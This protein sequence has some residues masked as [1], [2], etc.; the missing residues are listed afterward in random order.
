L[1]SGTNGLNEVLIK[2]PFEL[3]PNPSADQFY[4]KSF[5][6]AYDCIK[7]YDA[8][9]RLVH[10]ENHDNTEK[11]SININLAE[12]IYK[13]EILLSQCVLDTL[14]WIKR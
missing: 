11:K 6:Q 4:I 10:I 8:M 5:G 3:Y 9:G 7:I 12:G 2:R 13:V 14:K 1:V